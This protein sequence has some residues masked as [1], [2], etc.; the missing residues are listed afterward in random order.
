MTLSVLLTWRAAKVFDDGGGG[1]FEEEGLLGG[2][3]ISSP[4]SSANRRYSPWAASEGLSRNAA[5]SP[6]HHTSGLDENCSA[7]LRTSGGTAGG[8]DLRAPAPP[9]TMPATTAGALM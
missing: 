9:S 8:S 4:C 5:S 3:S 6:D 1:F 2:G 7:S